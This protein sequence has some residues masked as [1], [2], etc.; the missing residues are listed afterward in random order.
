MNVTELKNL[1]IKFY[2]TDFN[3]FKEIMEECGLT[4]E[5]YLLEKFEDFKRD[6][7]DFLAKL[8]DRTAECFLD[9]FLKN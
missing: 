9:K 5:G 6:G 3:K 2:N 8:D 7:V 1:I 4:G